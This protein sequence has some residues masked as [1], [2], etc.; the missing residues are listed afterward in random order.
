MLS[1]HPGNHP[2]K[3]P[4]RITT[5]T[6]KTEQIP[7][8]GLC[9]I[10]VD[11]KI[12]ESDKVRRSTLASVPDTQSWPFPSHWVAPVCS[13]KVGMNQ[14]TQSN[15]AHHMHWGRFQLH[16]LFWIC[17]KNKQ[18]NGSEHPPGAGLLPSKTTNFPPIAV[19]MALGL[20]PSQWAPVRLWAFWGSRVQNLPAEQQECGLGGQAV[21]TLG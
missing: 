7:S 14:E 16:Q 21:P 8:G 3:D 6:G 2:L 11:R 20:F 17:E 19:S 1:S 13:R 12:L 9:S 15:E 5:Q 10:G 4:G 18:I